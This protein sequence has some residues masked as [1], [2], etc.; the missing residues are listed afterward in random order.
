MTAAIYKLDT[1]IALH[2]CTSDA[3]RAR[4]APTRA[5]DQSVPRGASSRR[6]PAALI[7]RWP[8]H[9]RASGR[10]A[11]MRGAAPLSLTPF[12]GTSGVGWSWP[13]GDE[14]RARRI[15]AHPAAPAGTPV[16]PGNA[17]TPPPAPDW[18]C[19]SGRAWLSSGRS[20]KGPDPIRRRALRAGL[21]VPRH[22]RSPPGSILLRSI[23]DRTSL[24]C[25]LWRTTE[26]PDQRQKR[27]FS[28]LDCGGYLSRM[29]DL[30]A[31]RT[32]D[33]RVAD[34]RKPLAVARLPAWAYWIAVRMPAPHREG[35]IWLPG[36]RAASPGPSRPNWTQLI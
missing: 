14:P 12:D 28:I 27:A 30:L 1:S 32:Q 18:G 26:T 4:V 25:C 21:V 9:R 36:L 6:S 29:A 2:A 15:L 3:D 24:S 34:D 20:R 19:R 31:G 10:A 35:V 23:Q 22:R 17:H 5:H 13:Q 7:R 16:A 11:G 8:D 33:R